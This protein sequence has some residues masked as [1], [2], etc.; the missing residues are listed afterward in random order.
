MKAQPNSHLTQVGHTKSSYIK[1]FEKAVLASNKKENLMVIDYGAGKGHGTKILNEY[2]ETYRAFSFE[3]TPKNWSPDVTDS[4]K[5]CNG[6]F[7]V[8]ICLNVLNVLQPQLRAKVVQDIVSKLKVGGVACIGTRAWKDD[9][10]RTKNFRDTPEDKALWVHK[11]GKDIYQKGYDGSEL[12]D[13]ITEL[14]GDTVSKVQ[15][16]NSFCKRGVIITK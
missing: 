9:V 6:I 11:G 13:Y 4:D 3:P 10:A 1:A 16:N 14:L 12:L 5:L 8:V 2:G 7:D 15:A